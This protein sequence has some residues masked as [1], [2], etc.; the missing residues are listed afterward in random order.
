MVR[1][2]DEL[3]AIPAGVGDDL[4]ASR[5]ED[6]RS[7][8]RTLLATKIEREFHFGECAFELCGWNGANHSPAV[9]A[10]YIRFIS[11]NDAVQT[12]VTGRIAKGRMR[13]SRD[14]PMCHARQG[15]L[16]VGRSSKPN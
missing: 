1:K 3:S 2:P 13:H 15:L 16:E 11:A 4:R 10:F 9:I 12:S 5:K 14:P 8:V 6:Y 7:A